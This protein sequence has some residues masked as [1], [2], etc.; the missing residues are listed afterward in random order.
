MSR[1]S[2]GGPH[3]TPP[4]SEM[5]YVERTATQ[6]NMEVEDNILPPSQAHGTLVPAFNFSLPV[7]Q[8]TCANNMEASNPTPTYEYEVSMEPSPPAVIS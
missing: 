8:P 4:P 2:V 1:V 5:D 6:N 3:S 7:S